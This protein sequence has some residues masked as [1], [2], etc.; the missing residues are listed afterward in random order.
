MSCSAA[1]RVGVGLNGI[2]QKVRALR[3]WW[4]IS[5]VPALRREVDFC[6]FKANQVYTVNSRAEPGLCREILSYPASPRLPKIK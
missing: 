1:G 4:L 2:R 5:L 6:E 3:V